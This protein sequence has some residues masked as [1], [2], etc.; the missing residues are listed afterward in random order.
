MTRKQHDIKT[1]R[2]FLAAIQGAGVGESKE[3]LALDAQLAMARLTHGLRQ[4]ETVR[5]IPPVRD[6]A[7]VYMR[8]F[9]AVRDWG[10]ISR[11]LPTGDRV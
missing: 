8:G 7:Q 9:V 5:D 2:M 6:A 4:T 10:G 11:S 1:V 3:S